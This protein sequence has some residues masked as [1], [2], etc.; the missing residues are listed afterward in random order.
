MDGYT[1]GMGSV[2][3][4]NVMILLGMG[5]FGWDIWILILYYYS[6]LLC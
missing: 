3:M 6:L 2:T 5:S 1:D 4:M